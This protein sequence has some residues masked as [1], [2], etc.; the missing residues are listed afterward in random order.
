MST[1]AGRIQDMA[2][3]ACGSSLQMLLFSQGNKKQCHQQRKKRK[4][5][6]NFEERREYINYILPRDFSGGPV[7]RN[8]PFNAGDVGSVPDRGTDI[9]QTKGQLS[10]CTATKDPQQRASAAKIKNKTVVSQ[11]RRGN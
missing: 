4:Q 11:N 8:L 7:V 5:S 9:P 2:M 3:G 10:P 6:E 1:D